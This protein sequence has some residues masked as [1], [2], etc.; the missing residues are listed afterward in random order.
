MVNTL[1][2]F[3]RRI[4]AHVAFVIGEYAESGRPLTAKKLAYR[5]TVPRGHAFDTLCSQ[6]R[7]LDAAVDSQTARDIDT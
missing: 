5:S 7:P 6:V 1:A 2:L 4:N 3:D